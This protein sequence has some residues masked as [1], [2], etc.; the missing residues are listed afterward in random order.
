MNSDKV[1]L[2]AEGKKT[3][4]LGLLDLAGGIASY[5][6]MASDVQNFKPSMTSLG[7]SAG[8]AMFVVKSLPKSMTDLKDTLTRSVAFAKKND[9]AVSDQVSK[10]L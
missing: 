8:A 1:V 4:A 2:T 9:I 6:G 10:F 5:A 7:S 3:F